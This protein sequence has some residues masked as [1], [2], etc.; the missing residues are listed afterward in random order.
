MGTPKGTKPW[1]AGTS[2]GWTDRR[3]YRWIWVNGKKVREHRHIM[4]QHLG[5]KLTPEEI[6]HHKNGNPSDN[7]IE[8]LEVTTWSLHTVGHGS[9]RRQTEHQR[10]TLAVVA[11]YREKVNRLE[12]VNTALLAALE[13]CVDGMERCV[14]LAEAYGNQGNQWSRMDATPTIAEMYAS[15]AAL[16][17][18]RAALIAARSGG[19]SGEVAAARGGK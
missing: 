11:Q 1:N 7:R 8:N 19:P 13:A 2:K 4:E 17:Q 16:T 6:V 3:G 10:R 9:G 14:R 15:M 5:R 18:A 12:E